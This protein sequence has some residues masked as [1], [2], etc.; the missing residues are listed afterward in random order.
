MARPGPA[1]AHG[2]VAPGGFCAGLGRL[3]GRLGGG[4]VAFGV[5][6]RHHCSNTRWLATMATRKRYPGGLLEAAG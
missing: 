5:L 2:R 1:N 3:G 6:V 4:G